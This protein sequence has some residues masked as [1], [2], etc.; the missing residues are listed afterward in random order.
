MD[1]PRLFRR[2][3]FHRLLALAVWIALYAWIYSILEEPR[4]LLTVIWHFVLATL[5]LAMTVA[6]SAQF[7]LPVRSRSERLAV[8]Q[9]VLG[10]LVGIR[11]PVMFVQNGKAIEGPSERKRSGSGVLLIDQASSA[12]LRTK[13]R[14]TRAVG[15]GVSFTSPE[16]HLAEA[17]DLRRQVRSIRPENPFS[18]SPV[19]QADIASLARTE[20]GIPI[21]A[22]ISVTFILDPGHSNPPR[23]GSHSHLPPFEFNPNSAEKA[24][25]GQTILE[26][27][28]VPWTEIPLRLVADLWREEAKN[29]CLEALFTELKDQIT[30]LEHIQRE[31]LKRL[32]SSS[33]GHSDSS[34]LDLKDS[35]REGE[36]L[37]ARGIRVLD[38][39]ISEIQLPPDIAEGHTE[40]WREQWAGAVQGALSQATREADL[41][42]QL[43]EQEAQENLARELTTELRNQLAKGRK[44]GLRETL[45]MLLQDA[46][47]I[48]TD[49][50]LVADGSALA[51]HLRQVSD[52]VASLDSDCQP[53]PG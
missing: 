22:Q 16:E 10:Y 18:D 19:E 48:C 27:V 3:G 49:Q 14:F 9:R 53:R 13:T 31:I 25:Y 39:R 1:R 40:R 15:P 6:V 5:S 36:I 20:D 8:I 11:G 45:S 52:E 51:M 42:R 12:V 28:D 17:L 47:R 41:A 29:W 44:P 34:S 23:E 33:N 26:G 21:A 38:V 50:T 7:V 43:G 2:P 35:N 30:P 4:P 24:V 37:R 32:Q 46:V